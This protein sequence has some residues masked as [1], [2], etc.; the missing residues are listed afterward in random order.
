MLTTVIS[1]LTNVLF[2]NSP[3]LTY[4][5]ALALEAFPKLGSGC[6]GHQP[7]YP[8]FLVSSETPKYYFL[9]P[10]TTQTEMSY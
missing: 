4:K 9:L 1:P 3:N 10:I 8:L 2:P 5:Q 6:H 7:N